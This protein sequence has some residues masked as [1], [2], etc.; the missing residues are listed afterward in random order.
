MTLK[1]RDMYLFRRQSGSRLLVSLLLVF[2]VLLILSASQQ[3]MTPWLRWF[4]T[5]ITAL[6]GAVL[7]GYWVYQFQQKKISQL[8]EEATLDGILGIQNAK[9]C[10][11]QIRQAMEESIRYGN[12]FS[13]C[14]MDV[15]GLKN[16]NDQHG[17]ESGDQL[18]REIVTLTQRSIRPSDLLFRYRQGDEFL[19]LTKQTSAEGAL[20]LAERLR[21][22][23]E[24][25]A[26]TGVKSKKSIHVTVSL[27]V[28]GFD[29]AKHSSLNVQ[30][31]LDRAENALHRAKQ[32]K[33]T[34]QLVE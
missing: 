10:Q 34:V 32:T 24:D 20:C 25:L 31:L 16:T 1:I 6:I 9:A 33:N 5:L 27:G 26:H 3:N 18:L 4:S 14:L 12:L 19:V 21:S 28:T 30:Q 7:S 17:Y 11:Q 23:V 8:Q 15:D 13:I 2:V 29:P 22:T